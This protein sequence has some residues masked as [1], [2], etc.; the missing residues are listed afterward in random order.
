VKMARLRSVLIISLSVFFVTSACT[1][2]QTTSTETPSPTAT[3][4][5]TAPTRRQLA[6][7]P[8]PSSE[9]QSSRPNA[10]AQSSNE[11]LIVGRWQSRSNHTAPISG[12]YVLITTA[13]FHSDG[14]YEYRAN[15]T[16]DPNLSFQRSGQWS[17]VNDNIISANVIDPNSGKVYEH[18]YR[19]AD[20]NT[21]INNYGKVSIRLP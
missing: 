15:N 18:K 19:I 2:K 7:S 16:S 13:I 1:S 9:L 12:N 10:Q 5:P 11:S 14:T 20:Q 4:T 6:P 21:I 8:S 17:R 3:P